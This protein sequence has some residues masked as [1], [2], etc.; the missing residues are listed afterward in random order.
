MR[1]EERQMMVYNMAEREH[2]F[3]WHMLCEQVAQSFAM[4]GLLLLGLAHL[5]GGNRRGVMATILAY[6]LAYICWRCAGFDLLWTRFV[7]VV[8]TVMAIMFTTWSILEY[9]YYP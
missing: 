9:A 8:T 7:T 1:G 6:T 3:R 5:H 2:A 4:F